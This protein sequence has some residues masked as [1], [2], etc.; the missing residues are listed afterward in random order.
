MVNLRF[1]ILALGLMF[2]SMNL[3]AGDTLSVSGKLIEMN[4]LLYSFRQQ[5]YANSVMR[6]GQ[7]PFSLTSVLLKGVYEDRGSAA[8]IQEGDG[9]KQLEADV[10][11]FVV[12]NPSSRL[13]GSA[14]YQNGRRNNV[15]WNENADFSLLYPYVTGDSLGGFMKEET[16]RFSGGYVRAF[17]KWRLATELKY[18]AMLAY[19]DKDPRPRNIV[20]DLELQLSASRL[21]KSFYHLGTS[22]SLRTYDQKSSISFLGDKGSTSVY[23]MLGLGMDYVRFAGNEFSSQ[24]QGLGAS[25][26]I[27]LIP[28]A[29]HRDY[30]GFGISVLGSYFRLSKKLDGIS[31]EISAL[32]QYNLAFETSWMKQ[33]HR[34]SYG[35]KL[36]GLLHQRLGRETIFGEQTNGVYT[37]LHDVEQFKSPIINLKLSGFYQMKATD[38]SLGG[39]FVLPHIGYRSFAPKYH[40]AGRKVKMAALNGGMQ[41]QGM[42]KL[43]RVLLTSDLKVGYTSNISH[44]QLLPGVNAQTSVGETV[45]TN[46]SYLRDNHADVDFSLRGDYVWSAEYSFQLTARWKHEKYQKNGKINLFELSLGVVF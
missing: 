10:K 18:R 38:H 14:S 13:F 6:F 31:Q 19:R 30:D 32:D 20:S 26:S 28:A 12:L 43:A 7:L 1:C 9:K 40:S 11:S 27:E 34:R 24:Y 46:L 36:E 33:I 21:L 4:D 8:I 22:F 2:V 5:V 16:Y 25:V 37:K 39:W 45:I 35:V 41:I 17:D 15:R 3:K 42:R 29:Q 44:R 23:Q